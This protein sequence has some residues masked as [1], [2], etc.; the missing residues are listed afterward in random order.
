MPRQGEEPF[1]FL[2]SGDI[3]TG[4]PQDLREESF[5]LKKQEPRGTEESSR[6]M[7]SIFQV[8]EIFRQLGKP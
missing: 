7:S 8:S 5:V 1:L 6:I 4:S 2:F 3:F